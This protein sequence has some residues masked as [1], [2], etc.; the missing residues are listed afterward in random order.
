MSAKVQVSGRTKKG[1]VQIHT[2]QTAQRCPK[3][4]V[5]LKERDGKV[6]CPNG[7]EACVDAILTQA[8]EPVH[9]SAKRKGKKWLFW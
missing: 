9:G 4:K 8:V 6:Y 5:P 3:H 7:G 2:G 1:S